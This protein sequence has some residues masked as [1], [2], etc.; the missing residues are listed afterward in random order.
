MKKDELRVIPKK[1]YIILAAVL[2]FSFLFI[3]YLYLWFESYNEAKLNMPIMNKYM[4]VINYNELSDYLVEN[5][6]TIIY[7]S[8]LENNDIRNFEKKFKNVFK[9]HEIDKDI[10]YMDITNEKNINKE[11]YMIG[12]TS[13]MDVPVIMVFDGGILKN[14]YSIKHNNYDIDNLKEYINSINYFE[15][16]EIDG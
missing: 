9:R 13:I 10:I 15:D 12:N 3:Y 7:V 6:N 14:I 2:L 16:G 11:D 1:N 8:V 4:D 5:P